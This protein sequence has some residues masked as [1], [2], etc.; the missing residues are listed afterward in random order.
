LLKMDKTENE[1]KLS[2]NTNDDT[3]F[4]YYVEQLDNKWKVRTTSPALRTGQLKIPRNQLDSQI[5]NFRIRAVADRSTSLLS[6]SNI[7]S[8]RQSAKIIL[9]NAFSPNNDGLNDIFE[10]E[11]IYISQFKISVYNR[12]GELV[13]YSDNIKQAWDGKMNGEHLPEGIYVYR[14]EAV[15]T[16]GE[17]LVLQGTISILR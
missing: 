3:P 10:L 16:I 15:D 14:I 1:V 11:G 9:P 8:F 2:W 5:T 13:Y 17:P 6:Y 4:S 7:T 12:W